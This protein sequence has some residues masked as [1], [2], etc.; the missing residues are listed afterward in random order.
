MTCEDAQLCIQDYISGE[1]SPDRHEPLME[2]LDDCPYCRKYFDQT[3]SIQATLKAALQ[4]SVP[5]DLQ[6]SVRDLLAN[7]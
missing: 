4:Y 5:A 6:N 2:H 7:A 1:L 3:K